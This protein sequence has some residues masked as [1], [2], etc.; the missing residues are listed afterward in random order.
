MLSTLCAKYGL[1]YTIK[2]NTITLRPRQA[3]R[4]SQQRREIKGHVIDEAGLPL[5]GVS[6]TVKGEGKRGT[7]TDMD[8]NFKLTFDADEKPTLQFSMVGM[9]S[10]SVTVRKKDELNIVMRESTNTLNEVVNLP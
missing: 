4:S 5:P 9:E 1:E 6:V 7:S 8:G 10:Q 3:G 2:N